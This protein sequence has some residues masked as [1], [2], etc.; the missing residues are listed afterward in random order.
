MGFSLNQTCCLLIALLEIHT[1][2]DRGGDDRR[3][4]TMIQLQ[5]YSSLFCFMFSFL[6]L[7]PKKTVDVNPIAK[8]CFQLQDLCIVPCVVVVAVSSMFI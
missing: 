2:L 4:Q 7:S 8:L 6:C 5:Y 1:N 3:C